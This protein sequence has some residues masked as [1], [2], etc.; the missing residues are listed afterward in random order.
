MDMTRIQEFELRNTVTPEAIV[1][2]Q[3]EDP[4]ALLSVEILDEWNH[5]VEVYR[6][7][8]TTLDPT[9]ETWIECVETAATDRVRVEVSGGSGIEAIG[10]AVE[11]TVRWSMVTN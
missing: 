1:I 8:D 4:Q 2:V 3:G 11:D 9:A 7:P 6:G 5:W 10:V